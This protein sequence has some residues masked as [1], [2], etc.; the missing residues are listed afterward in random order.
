MSLGRYIFIDSGSE[1]ESVTALFHYFL[2]SQDGNG[3]GNRILR[4]D[5]RHPM[6]CIRFVYGALIAGVAFVSG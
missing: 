3:D 5:C 6:V 1:W 2:A 4:A